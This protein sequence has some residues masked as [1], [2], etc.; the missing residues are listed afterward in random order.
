MSNTEL[1]R[2][3]K[4]I[5]VRA[6]RE[7]VWRALTDIA[8]FGQWFRVKSQDTFAPGARVHMVSTHEGYAGYSF[9]VFVEEMDP[10]R[11][12]SWRWHPGLREPE[13]DYYN[14][15][16]TLVTFD[17]EEVAGGTL[18]KVTES[19]FSHISLVRRAKVFQENSGGW[20]Y[21]LQQIAQYAGPK[22]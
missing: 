8:E 20:E 18:V 14:E 15:S 11:R 3:E 10:P 19:G 17:L 21:Q 22:A 9:Y 4:Q 7:R 12:F 5:V 13:I 6:P 1:N 2:I 16:T